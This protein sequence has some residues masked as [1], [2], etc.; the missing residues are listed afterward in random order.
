MVVIKL[1]NFIIAW[2]VTFPSPVVQLRP[3][4]NPQHGEATWGR[5]LARLD[6]VL[7]T[8]SSMLD[9]FVEIWG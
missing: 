2:N 7:L 9:P 3:P 1:L 4:Q 5:G 6:S 8:D